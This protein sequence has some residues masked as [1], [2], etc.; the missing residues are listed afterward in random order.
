MQQCVHSKTESMSYKLVQTTLTF[1]LVTL[2]WVL[3]RADSLRD[4]GSYMYRMCTRLRPIHFVST[5]LVYEG[6]DQIE[7]GILLGALLV[8][9]LVSLVKFNKHLTLDLFLAEQSLWFRWLVLYGLL[10][11][12]IIFGEYGPKYSPQAF[13]YFQF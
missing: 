10:F 1:L 6:F 9:F 5:R 8:L 11:A 4:A 13:I 12:I 2:A 3:F 7:W